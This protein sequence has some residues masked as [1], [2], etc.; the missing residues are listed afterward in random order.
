MSLLLIV[1]GF[2]VES[3]VDICLNEMVEDIIVLMIGTDQVEV[4]SVYSLFF[5]RELLVMVLM[6]AGWACGR[7]ED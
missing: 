1:I 2:S 5:N 4:E 7:C 6:D 3:L